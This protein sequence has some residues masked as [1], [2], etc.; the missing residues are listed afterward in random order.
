[1]LAAYHA[2]ELSPEEDAWI[3]EHFVHCQEC[4]E[5]L[6]DLSRFAAPDRAVADRLPDGWITAAWQSLRARL[7]REPG[8]RLRRR[9]Q[10]LRSLQGAYCVAGVLLAATLGLSVW[11]I[12][13]HLELR[14]L[15]EPQANVQI[16]T[17][18]LSTRSA[19]PLP[20]QVPAGGERF[21]LSVATA[22]NAPW[23]ECREVLLQIETA[24]GHSLWSGGLAPPEDGTITLELSRRAL[25]A[26]AYRL[27]IAGTAR[28]RATHEE[29]HA[30][31][32]SY[33]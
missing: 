7:A 31:I 3:R 16:E 33:L 10:W 25:P 28:C 15:R 17:L 5:L 14:R 29:R 8:A 20:I 24:E 6:L 26:G 30:F 19:D 4:P 32:L 9:L 13:L 2:N 22:A 11:V 12:G 23:R 27:R 1:M 18:D 21:L